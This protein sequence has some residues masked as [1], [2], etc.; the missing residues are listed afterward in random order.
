MAAHDIERTRRALGLVI[1]LDNEEWHAA[2]EFMAEMVTAD[3]VSGALV[4][5]ASVAGHFASQLALALGKP[6]EEI[7]AEIGLVLAGRG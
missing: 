1:A 5:L 4:E 3:G 2:C 7:Y 6:V